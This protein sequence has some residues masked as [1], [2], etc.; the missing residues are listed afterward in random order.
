MHCS[1]CGGDG[2]KD[3]GGGW[4]AGRGRGMRGSLRV[5]KGRWCGAGLF[6]FK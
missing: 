5:A 1:E 2:C 6:S 4:G 3:S